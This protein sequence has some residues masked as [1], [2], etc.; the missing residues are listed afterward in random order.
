MIHFQNQ[1]TWSKQSS[2]AILS[3]FFF[4]KGYWIMSHLICVP[5]I[6]FNVSR[7]LLQSTL[8]SF[9][10][11]GICSACVR[12]FV[13]VGQRH[14]NELRGDSSCQGVAMVTAAHEQCWVE[15]AQKTE[16]NPEVHIHVHAYTLTQLKHTH[17]YSGC[18]HRKGFPPEWGDSYLKQ[19]LSIIRLAVQT[20]DCVIKPWKCLCCLFS[21]ALLG[22]LIYWAVNCK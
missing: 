9:S 22:I 2:Q 6:P 12:V 4:F 19:K 8:L 18:S 1:I 7:K 21:K 3:L 10:V 16:W 15:N 17:T 5:Q 13:C 20:R 14:E 11:Y